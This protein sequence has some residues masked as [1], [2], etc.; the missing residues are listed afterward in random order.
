[1][2]GMQSPTCEYLQIVLNS[3]PLT[4]LHRNHNL[5]GF[6]G[7]ETDY[8]GPYSKNALIKFQ[9]KKNLPA[10]GKITID[11][12]VELDKILFTLQK[13]PKKLIPSSWILKP[14]YIENRIQL[15]TPDN[16]HWF[17]KVED[18]TDH[19]NGWINLST[20]NFKPSNQK[21]LKQNITQFV[22]KID[23]VIGGVTEKIIYDSVRSSYK[24]YLPESY[25]T[26]LLL[27][28]IV[29]E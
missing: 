19:L 14:T 20:I 28:L 2:E 13:G 17:L 23:G 12:A 16:I 27:A 26:E 3:N 10:N 15:F 8:F 9:K 6:E 5:A 4:C 29:H 24:N 21:M 25:P 7:K 1:M 18:P 22:P 11:T